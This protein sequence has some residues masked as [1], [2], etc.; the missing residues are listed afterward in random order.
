MEYG[1][2]LLLSVYV[3]TENHGYTKEALD[4]NAKLLEANPEY[5]TVWNY[6]KFDVEYILSHLET[7]TEIDPDSIKS[8]LMKNESYAFIGTTHMKKYI[9]F[10]YIHVFDDV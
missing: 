6:R 8:I 1:A 10:F 3:L 5:L 2:L 7:D 9:Y 4:V